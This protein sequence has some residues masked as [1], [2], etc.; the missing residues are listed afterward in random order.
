M[1]ISL[2]SFIIVYVLVYPFGGK[3]PE[4]Q[5]P[6]SFWREVSQ[7]PGTLIVAQPTNQQT[8]N[9]LTAEELKYSRNRGWQS[10]PPTNNMLEVWQNLA[11]FGGRPIS[12]AVEALLTK[13]LNRRSSVSLIVFLLLPPVVPLLPQHDS[14]VITQSN[15]AGSIMLA[16][17]SAETIMLSVH[18]ESIILSAPPAE[19]II[20]SAPPAESMILSAPRNLQTL[21]HGMATMRCALK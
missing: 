20:V 4:A 6:L 11:I 12:S 3:P 5:E 8:T 15:G 13:V 1:Y 7:S 19:S 17:G 16:V 21:R 2:C 18:A 14:G 9:R 10:R